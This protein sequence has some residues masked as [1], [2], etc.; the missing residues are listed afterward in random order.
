MATGGCDLYRYFDCTEDLPREIDYLR[1]HDQAI[2]G[3]GVSV[4]LRSTHS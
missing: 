3:S 1:R 4:F 2:R